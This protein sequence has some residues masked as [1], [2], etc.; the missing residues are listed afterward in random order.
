MRSFMLAPLFLAMLGC[1]EE[2]S[3]CM[4][5]YGRAADDNCYPLATA[6][7]GGDDS[8][9]ANDTDTGGGG[10]GGGTNPGGRINV[11][12]S[13]TL[14]VITALPTT[15]QNCALQAHATWPPQGGPIGVRTLEKCPETLNTPTQFSVP[16]EMDN[17]SSV[18]ITAVLQTADGMIIPGSHTD[19]LQIVDGAVAGVELTIDPTATGPSGGGG[20][21][22]GTG[23]G[24]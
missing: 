8:S 17:V 20:G 22:G 2:P 23:T 15:G 16:F 21:G 6:D 11:Q 12:V 4:A 13:G 7:G 18:H 14:E 19:E 5:G 1:A 9:A 10:G 24:N 3:D